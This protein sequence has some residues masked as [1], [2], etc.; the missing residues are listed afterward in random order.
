[1]SFKSYK[2]RKFQN[3]RNKDGDPFINYSLTIPSPI[4]EK[5]PEDMHFE[6][7]LT[8]DGILFRP[9]VEEVVDVNLPGWAKNQRNGKT[10]AQAQTKSQRRKRPAAAKPADKP[11]EAE[12]PTEPVA[13]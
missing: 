13:A 5:L 2:I 3:G 12:A 11:A 10:M 4:A 1:M 9:A 7:E 6:C 8:D